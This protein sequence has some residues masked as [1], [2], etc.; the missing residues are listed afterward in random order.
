MLTAGKTVGKAAARSAAKKAAKI[1][2]KTGFFKV[3]LSSIKMGL[4]SAAGQLVGHY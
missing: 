1:A 3:A 4:K 2:V